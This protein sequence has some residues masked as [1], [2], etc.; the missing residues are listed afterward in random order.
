M[1]CDLLMF[2]DQ[3]TQ[4]IPSHDPPS[5]HQD[6]WHAG[7]KGRR[8]ARGVAFSPDG[9]RLAAAPGLVWDVATGEQQLTLLG[10]AG[11]DPRRHRQ[12]RRDPPGHERL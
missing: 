12:P 1:A 9:R 8:L 10:H 3:P 5:R 11:C 2:M 7:P 6:N 4:P